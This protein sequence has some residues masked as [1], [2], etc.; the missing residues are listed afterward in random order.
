MKR[1][2]LNKFQLKQ[3][4]GSL[5][6]CPLIYTR[7]LPEL[8]SQIKIRDIR[9]V[10]TYDLFIFRKFQTFPQYCSCSAI[11]KNYVVRSLDLTW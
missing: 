2:H 7:K 11:E 1:F 6:F 10:V 9:F 8:T 5:S 4:T 3:K